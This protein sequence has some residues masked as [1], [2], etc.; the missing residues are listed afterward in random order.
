MKRVCRPL[1]ACAAVLFAAGLSGCGDKTAKAVGAVNR[2]NIQRLANMYSA[3]Q[4]YKGGRGPATETEF[5]EF[6]STFDV[7]KLDMMGIKPNELDGL[8]RSERDNKPFNI[9]YNVGGGRG[10]VDA[11]I[12]EVEGKDGRKQVAYTGDSKVEDLDDASYQALW[13]AK[14]GPKAK[15]DPKAGGGPAGRP[16]GAPSG[17]VK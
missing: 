3:F 6:I 8:F 15:A 16:A 4:N 1:M 5:R 14:S 2:S 11:V 12:F 9:R 13:S 17:P 7:S 10:T